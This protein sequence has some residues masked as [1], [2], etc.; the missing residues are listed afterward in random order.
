MYSKEEEVKIGVFN[1]RVTRSEMVPLWTHCV[2]LP[3]VIL[4]SIRVGFRAFII[5]NYIVSFGTGFSLV[6]KRFLL[7][8]QSRKEYFE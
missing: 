4:L 5:F 8:T 7:F 2:F 3:I 6:G 1:P